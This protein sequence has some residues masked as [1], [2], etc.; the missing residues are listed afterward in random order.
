[1]AGW[2]GDNIGGRR[3]LSQ[4]I[5]LIISIYRMASHIKF[6]GENTKEFRNKQKQQRPAVATGIF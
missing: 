5:S 3:Q 6:E 2:A 1:M 4:N